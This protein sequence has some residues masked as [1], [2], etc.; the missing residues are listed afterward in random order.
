MWLPRALHRPA[1]EWCWE[2]WGKLYPAHLLNHTGG[3]ALGE[4]SKEG[5]NKGE[6]GGS[7]AAH[8]FPIKHERETFPK[9]KI[10]G[11]QAASATLFSA[12]FNCLAINA[13]YPIPVARG[14]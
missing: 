12:P 3:G 7:Q 8:H 14:N 9:V 1:G 11:V 10:P 4:A 6:N 13:F 2:V 5:K